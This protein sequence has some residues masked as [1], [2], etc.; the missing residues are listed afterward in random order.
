MATFS[1]SDSLSVRERLAKT[2]YNAILRLY[3]DMAKKAKEEAAKLQNTTVSGRLQKV[4]LEK[5]AKQLEEEAEKVGQKVE[6]IVKTSMKKASEAVISDAVDFSKAIGITMEG[7]YR[8]VP[9]DIVETLVSGQLYQGKWSL[10]SAIWADVKKTQQDINKVV[11]EGLALNK[12]SYEIAKELE[13]YVDPAAKKDWDWSKVYPGTKKKVDYSAQRL[14]RT[15]VGHAYEQSAVAVAKSNP[16][17]DGIKWISGHSN[18]TCEICKERNG[19]IFPADKLPL[20]HPNGKC[21]FAPVVTK[22]S[23]DIADELADWVQGK[24]NKK[25]DKWAD[26]MCNGANLGKEQVKLAAT[27]KK[28]LKVKDLPKTTL[29]EASDAWFEYEEANLMAEYI[30]TGIMPK[31]N[32]Y[33]QPISVDTQERLMAQA[34]MLQENASKSRVNNKILYRG[35]VIQEEE[36][37]SAFKRNS[38]YEF[39]TLSATATS[40]NIASIYADVE[41]AGGEGTAVILEIENPKGVRGYARDDIEVILPKGASYRVSR[42]YYKDGVLHV[43]LYAS[44]GLG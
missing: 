2:Q 43:S 44:K 22:S 18:T 10:S 13:K 8:R 17:V 39:D 24:P 29:Q 12:S 26:K 37:L 20:D 15:M 19:K 11:A 40:E 38:I 41:N 4:E 7:A 33:Q 3:K 31:V 36:D 28:P 21:S 23:T 16:F 9:A 35:M 6:A 27:T 32:M 30:K 25:I 5:L 14:A 34:L 42:T 1:L